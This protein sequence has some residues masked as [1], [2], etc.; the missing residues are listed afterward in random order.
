MIQLVEKC[1]EHCCNSQIQTH[2]AEVQHPHLCSKLLMTPHRW[3]E[4]SALQGSISVRTY[5]AI[6][7]GR[8]N[9]V[10]TVALSKWKNCTSYIGSYE[11]GAITITSRSHAAFLS[12]G[13][14]ECKK[15]LTRYSRR[16]ISLQEDTRKWVWVMSQMWLLRKAFYLEKKND[17]AWLEVC[18]SRQ[19]IFQYIQSSEFGF[20][21]HRSKED[22][23]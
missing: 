17:V 2:H 5:H 20:A 14:M 9:R 21:S 23:Q 1:W 15:A 18:Q 22:L 6:Q 3:M 11:W 10:P 8:T 7:T 16:T 13:F 19:T 4:P 12:P